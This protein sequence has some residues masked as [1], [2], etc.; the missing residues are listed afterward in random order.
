MKH[1]NRSISELSPA[2]VSTEE[3]S[4]SCSECSEELAAKHRWT[5]D[6]LGRGDMEHLFAWAA[7]GKDVAD[8]TVD[9]LEDLEQTFVGCEDHFGL[10]FRE[11]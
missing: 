10:F 3:E 8:L 5:I 6:E 7:F 4:F 11:G 1:L 9:E 2:T